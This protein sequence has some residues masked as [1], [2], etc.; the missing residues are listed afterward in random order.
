[1]YHTCIIELIVV[2]LTHV[3]P[4]RESEAYRSLLSLPNVCINQTH[5]G[6]AET[7]LF[8]RGVPALFRSSRLARSH[9]ELHVGY[10]LPDTSVAFLQL[11]RPVPLAQI[12]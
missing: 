7:I 2:Y 6:K 11:P 12:E 4:A 3:F 8:N 1:M 9:T 5:Y 10:R